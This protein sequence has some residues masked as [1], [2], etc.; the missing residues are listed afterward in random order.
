[1]DGDESS[2][3]FIHHAIELALSLGDFQKEVGCQSSAQSVVLKAAERI[4]KLI[5]FE[6]SAIYLVDEDTSDLKFAVSVPTNAG[7]LIESELN[8]LIENGTV[9]WAIRE[10][11]GIS[12]YSKD[13][14]R[15]VFLHVMSTCSRIRG[16]FIGL[17]PE[18]LK[19][20]PDVSL[21]ILSIILRNTANCIESLNYSS[22]LRRQN[23]ALETAIEEKTRRLVMYEKQLL[24]AQN[25]EAIAKLAGGIAHQFNN[26]LTSL[27]G[28]LDL[29]SM[30][31]D[32][33]STVAGYIERIHPITER[34]RYLTNNLLSYSQGG[35][36]LTRVVTLKE[37]FKDVFP[38]IQRAIKGSVKLS[39][40]LAEES[41]SIQVDMVQ[42]RMVI[43]A[44]VENAN[45]AIDD[46]GEITM[47]G[48]A[49]SPGGV[50]DGSNFSRFLCL[51]IRDNGR[52][53]D[54]ETM[55]RIFEP[56]FTTKFEGRGL[57]MAAV[58]GIIK[59]HMG[60]INVDSK[61]GKGTQVDIYL[62]LVAQDEVAR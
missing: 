1:M 51:S 45:E 15:Q 40:E 17:F 48:Y 19:R 20:L 10:R 22:M 4:E 30:S 14:R 57:S 31:I 59:N 49:A 16:L 47:C 7:Q 58:Y 61:I 26:A 62:P 27:I 32:S 52:G 6:T 25:M 2:R 37:I 46:D 42:L 35:K 28:Y 5:E 60:W 33:G 8:C 24:Q 12:L 41:M 21:E 53:M 44:V 38:V 29:T 50:D 23:E 43:L 18:Q 34:M 36:F 55:R 11:R 54:E 39:L 13:S 9:A 56:F 3:Q